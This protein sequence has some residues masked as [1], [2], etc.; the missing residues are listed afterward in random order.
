MENPEQYTIQYP[1]IIIAPF[2]SEVCIVAGII[3]CEKAHV[4]GLFDL[5]V[6]QFSDSYH[7]TTYTTA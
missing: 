6:I 4:P 7:S 1:M 5:I 3:K 2:T